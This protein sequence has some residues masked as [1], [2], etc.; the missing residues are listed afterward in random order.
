MPF[1]RW[2]FS[3]SMYFSMGGVEVHSDAFITLSGE[4]SVGILRLKRFETNFVRCLAPHCSCTAPSFS[5]LP[6]HLFFI[7]LYGLVGR[8]NNNSFQPS[9]DSLVLFLS[10][11]LSW[12]SLLTQTFTM[13]RNGRLD[14]GVPNEIATEDDKETVCY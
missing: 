3:A 11:S 12:Y 9:D 8:T 14:V 1:S 6:Y 7:P 5:A 4:S 13:R 10:N 2:T